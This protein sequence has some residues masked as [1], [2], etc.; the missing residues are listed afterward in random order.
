ME[1]DFC[2]NCGAAKLIEEVVDEG[3]GVATLFCDSIECSVINT[4]VKS[5]VFLLGE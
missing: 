4:K 3:N 1:V 5:T 2:V